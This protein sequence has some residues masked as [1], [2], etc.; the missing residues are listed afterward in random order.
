MAPPISPVFENIEQFD[1]VTVVVPSARTAP[2]EEAEFELSVQSVA[3]T[4]E[5]TA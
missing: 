4:M 5:L 1:V 2:P 3:V